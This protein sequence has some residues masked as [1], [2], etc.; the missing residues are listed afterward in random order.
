M[1]YPRFTPE[2]KVSDELVRVYPCSFWLVG[3][4]RIIKVGL[5]LIVLVIH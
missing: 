5:Q 1:A 2:G 3:N 4:S